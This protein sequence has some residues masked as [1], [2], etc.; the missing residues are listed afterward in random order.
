MND[1]GK[2]YSVFDEFWE[3]RQAEAMRVLV[4]ELN[5]AA[6]DLSEL[7]V[8]LQLLFGDGLLIAD[9]ALWVKN[10]DLHETDYESP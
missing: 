7:E 3:L 5:H 6:L 10:Y 9:I 1:Q 4:E 8:S 2:V